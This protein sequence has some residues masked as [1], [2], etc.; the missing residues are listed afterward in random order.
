M[1]Y[2]IIAAVCMWWESTDSVLTVETPA[3]VINNL[4]E[5][6]LEPSL[7]LKWRNHNHAVGIGFTWIDMFQA[8]Y[9]G[10]CINLSLRHT[11]MI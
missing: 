3:Q 6:V 1:R 11:L 8:R 2:N 7:N 10:N 4:T 5:L 9:Y